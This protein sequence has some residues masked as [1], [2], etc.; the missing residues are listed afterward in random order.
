MEDINMELNQ[1]I[2]ECKQV[3]EVDHYNVSPYKASKGLTEYVIRTGKSLLIT[4][5]E[6]SELEDKGEIELVGEPSEIWLGVPFEFKNEIFGA[7][8]VQH[9]HNPHA[10][11]EK[12]K[13]M[14]EFVSDQIARIIHLKRED[15]EKKVLKEKLVLSEK[16]EAVGRM[17]D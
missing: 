6:C 3:D 7:V 17:A 12:D 9:Y 8:V 4:D 10:Y 5:A 14:L 15:E 11:T 13:E 2:S 16:M 1:Q